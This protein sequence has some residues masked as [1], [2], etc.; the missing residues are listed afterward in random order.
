M[1]SASLSAV[2][3]AAGTGGVVSRTALAGI[4]RW[5]EVAVGAD[6]ATLLLVAGLADPPTGALVVEHEDE[7]VLVTG[8]GVALVAV[9]EGGAAL[10]SWALGAEAVRSAAALLDVPPGSA[11]VVDRALASAPMAGGQATAAVCEALEVALQGERR[12]VAAR[13]HDGLVQDLTAAQ[14]LLDSALWSDALPGDVRSPLE[15]GLAALR[16]AISGARV[17]MGDL[18]AGAADDS[19]P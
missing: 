19:G 5:A 10:A 6:A 18:L 11:A 4:A 12:E 7:L 2:V 17:L 15:D 1:A 3:G 9:S 16:S 8:P 14:L 13:L